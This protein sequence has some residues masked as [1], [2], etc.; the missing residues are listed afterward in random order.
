MDMH[1]CRWGIR[2]GHLIRIIGENSVYPGQ[3]ASNV[4]SHFYRECSPT[5]CGATLYVKN[6]MKFRKTESALIMSTTVILNNV[7]FAKD[8]IGACIEHAQLLFS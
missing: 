1:S 7:F 3:V 4:T 2:I 5:K 8:R 6:G